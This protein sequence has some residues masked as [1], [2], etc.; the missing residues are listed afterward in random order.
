MNDASARVLFSGGEDSTTCLAC[1]GTHPD[2]AMR[3]RPSR[4]ADL[5]VVDGIASAVIAPF[6]SS[7]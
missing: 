1:A 3:H 4:K 5:G 7:S 6:S 2:G